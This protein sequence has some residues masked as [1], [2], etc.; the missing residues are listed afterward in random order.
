M[1]ISLKDLDVYPTLKGEEILELL[2]GEATNFLNET[3]GPPEHTSIIEAIKFFI[4]RATCA[5]EDGE[6]IMRGRPSRLGMGA[7]GVNWFKERKFDRDSFF[8]WLKTKKIIAK[9]EDRGVKVD[10]ELDEAIEN[11]GR[12]SQEK[13][14][15]S[16]K[17]NFVND[18]EKPGHVKDIQLKSPPQQSDKQAI[19]LIKSLKVWCENDVEILIQKPNQKAIICT[20]DMLSFRD[21]NTKQWNNLIRLLKSSD[22]MF[23][24]GD[25]KNQAKSTWKVIEKKLIVFLSDKFNLSLP[26]NFKLFSPSQGEIGKREPLFK[27]SN[28]KGESGY[29]F[30]SLDRGEISEKIRELAIKSDVDT[31]NLLT[32]ACDRAKELGIT[33]DEILNLLKTNDLLESETSDLNPID[34]LDRDRPDIAGKPI[35]PEPNSDSLED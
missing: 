5:W 13:E 9:L 22:G 16:Q 10:E 33:E 7:R 30:N 34:S 26:D 12:N 14:R 4:Q 32:K 19:A 17:E 23:S 1:S 25:N 11:S 2:F 31:A 20:P 8:N 35:I 28:V 24:Y 15:E 18:S 6:I 21:A 29:N 27:V 3:P